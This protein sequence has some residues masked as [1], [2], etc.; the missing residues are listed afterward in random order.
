MLNEDQVKNF[1]NLSIRPLNLEI[2]KN[3]F[4]Y[5]QVKRTNKKFMYAQYQTG[6]D[7]IA[8]EVFYNKLGNMRKAKER[9]AKLQDREFDPSNYEEFYE[10]F[11][12]DEEFGKRA[13]T[14]K[15]LEQAEK[16]FASK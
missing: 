3:G 8:Y 4:T 16:A 7:I 2:R 5:R 9:W 10:V 1:S 15:T 11:P 6:R 13:W 14:Y 12:S